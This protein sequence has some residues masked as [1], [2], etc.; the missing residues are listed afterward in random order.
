MGTK[1]RLV[2]FLTL[3]VHQNPPSEGRIGG[4]QFDIGVAAERRQIEENSVLTGIGKS[5][6]GLLSV[7][8]NPNPLT[9]P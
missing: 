7:V 5:W 1:F 9:L 4:P 6:V 8:A 3:Y 2:P